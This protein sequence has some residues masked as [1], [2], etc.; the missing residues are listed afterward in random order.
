MNAEWFCSVLKTHRY[1]TSTHQVTKKKKISVEFLLIFTVISKYL[2]IYMPAI[3]MFANPYVRK[4]T[5]FIGIRGLYLARLT[6]ILFPAKW[7]HDSHSWLILLRLWS[8]TITRNYFYIK[9]IKKYSYR[10][11]WY[12]AFPY[13]T[14]WEKKWYARKHSYVS[15]SHHLLFCTLYLLNVKT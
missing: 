1:G 2:F 13:W 7:T 11:N 3:Y 15:I 10:I 5:Y 14:A 9:M 8:K 12:I 6:D 4:T